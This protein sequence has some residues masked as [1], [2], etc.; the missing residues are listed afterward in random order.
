M[1]DGLEILPKLIIVVVFCFIV[2][3]FAIIYSSYEDTEECKSD[4]ES[5]GLEFFKMRI[6]SMFS[7]SCSCV[8]NGEVKQIW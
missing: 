3:T 6:Q 5:L 2:I 7:E 4:C 1:N 8:K